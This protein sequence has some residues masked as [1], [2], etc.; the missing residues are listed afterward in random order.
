MARS[1]KFWQKVQLDYEI[2]GLSF[3]KLSVKHEI[4][5][6]AI[7]ARAKK[8]GWIKEKT[9]QLIEETVSVSRD[10]LNLQAKTGQ[11]KQ[12]EQ[13][14][15]NK[16]VKHRLEMEGIYSSFEKKLI[17]KADI[18]LDSIDIEED[19]FAASKIVQLSTA[20]KNM[21]PQPAATQVNVN[22]QNSTSIESDL[23]IEDIEREL[24]DLQERLL[25]HG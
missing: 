16:I 5:K 9:G 1:E 4:A 10:F 23:T 3:A 11:L 7:Q 14:E 6:S 20:F 13:A 17:K 18:V 12:A 25:D 8:D 2:H 24:A 21:R 19:N 15:I 22:Q